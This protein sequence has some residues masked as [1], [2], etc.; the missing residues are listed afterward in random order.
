MDPLTRTTQC[1]FPIE[2]RAESI[3]PV[4]MCRYIVEFCICDKASL[5][6]VSYD[7]LDLRRVDSCCV[8]WSETITSQTS[9]SLQLMYWKIPSGSSAHSGRHF[10][11][12][13]VMYSLS[14][15]SKCCSEEEEEVVEMTSLAPVSSG[16]V[17]VHVCCT[18]K[19]TEASN[20]TR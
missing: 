12:S 11:L 5:Q 1:T 18:V 20:T 2:P 13:F 3:L 19:R 9:A 6:T 10:R 4:L 7:V 16:D 15:R 14:L 8:G 17:F